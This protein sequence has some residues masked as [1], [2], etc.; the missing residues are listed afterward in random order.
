MQ[1]L[2]RPV[3]VLIN[4]TRIVAITLLYAILNTGEGLEPQV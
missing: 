2:F 4:L 3:T 1:P